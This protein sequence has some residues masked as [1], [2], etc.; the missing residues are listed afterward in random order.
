MTKKERFEFL[1]KNITCKQISRNKIILIANKTNKIAIVKSILQK[2]NKGKSGWVVSLDG[3]TFMDEIYD[4]REIA[5]KV[6]SK[7][8]I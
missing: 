7:N 5:I 3:L 4:T 6:A 8:L 2:R 1:S